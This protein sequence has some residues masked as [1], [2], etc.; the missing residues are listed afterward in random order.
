MPQHEREDIAR[1]DAARAINDVLLGLPLLDRLSA[2][3]CS[4]IVREPQSAFA[5]LTLIEVAL[6][7]AKHL[8]A[9]EQTQIVW[10]LNECAEE[11]KARWH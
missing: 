10:R 8:P 5:L 3:C 1:Q 2:L 4:L 11:L 7:L 6:Q 9:A